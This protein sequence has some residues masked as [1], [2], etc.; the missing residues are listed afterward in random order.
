MN[1]EDVVERCVN[2]SSLIDELKVKEESIMIWTCVLSVKIA[3][4][5]SYSK[6]RE[7]EIKK[8]VKSVEA[9]LEEIPE[10]Q[11]VETEKD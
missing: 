8:F 1:D 6:D 2:L 7:Y 10:Y 3:D 11:E 4:I 9:T 5:I